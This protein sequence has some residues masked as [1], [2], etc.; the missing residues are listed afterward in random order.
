MEL[1]IY[2]PFALLVLA[3]RS[4]TFLYTFRTAGSA[5][6]KYQH[7]LVHNIDSSDAENIF[8]IASK[9]SMNY[10]KNKLIPII[11]GIRLFISG[12]KEGSRFFKKLSLPL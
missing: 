7:L 6:F 5:A 9:K 11:R 12:F 4:D 10:R 3:Y 2:I 1:G 8:L